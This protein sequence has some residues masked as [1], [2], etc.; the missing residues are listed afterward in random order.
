MSTIL[1][2]IVV[3][4]SEDL[5]KRKREV[6]FNDL[7]SLEGYEK[8]R[9]DFKSALQKENQ[10]SVIA[11]VKKGSPSKG[12]IRENFD[13]LDIALRYEE[14][15]ASAISVLTDKPFFMGDLEYLN[16]ISKRVQIPLL[17]KDFIIDPFQIKEAR[18]YGADA[19]LIIVAITEGS[20]LNELLAAA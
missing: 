2:K 7:H 1:D 10:V 8:Q 17:R 5:I 9:I 4:T 13:P 11:E 6:S 3:Q 19:V 16:T 15:G 12:V 18:A 14:G 20:Q